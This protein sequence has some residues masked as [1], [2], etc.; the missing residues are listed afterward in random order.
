MDK[1]ASGGS[2]GRAAEIS[3]KY[4]SGELTAIRLDIHREGFDHKVYHYLS[5]AVKILQSAED[6][7]EEEG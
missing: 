3:S 2:A 1:T 7:L 4:I 5:E 6:P